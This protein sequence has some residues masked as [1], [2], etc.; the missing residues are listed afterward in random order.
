[1]VAV[2]GVLTTEPEGVLPGDGNS[3]RAEGVL[4][5]HRVV[6]PQRVATK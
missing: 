2:D 1:M 4:A 3:V 5:A 6:R